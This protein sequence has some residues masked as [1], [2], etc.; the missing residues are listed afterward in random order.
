MLMGWCTTVRDEN[1]EG[2]W[3]VAKKNKR[4]RRAEA[5]VGG[6]LLPCSKAKK[7]LHTLART[8]KEWRIVDEMNRVV[9]FICCGTCFPSS[10]I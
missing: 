2:W 4:P 9:F 5:E 3:S 6:W 7:G 1:E 8:K 10:L